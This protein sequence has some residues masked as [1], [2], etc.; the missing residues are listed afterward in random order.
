MRRLHAK[1]Q[2]LRADQDRGATAVEYAL[3]VAVIAV[4][5]VVGGLAVGNA[6]NGRFNRVGTCV[7]T[8]NGTNCP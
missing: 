3:I 6:I 5:L 8:P 1:L 7:T 4:I 2:A